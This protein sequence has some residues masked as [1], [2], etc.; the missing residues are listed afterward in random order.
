MFLRLGRG[1]RGKR[2]EKTCRK[3]R[4]GSDRKR[5]FAERRRLCRMRAKQ[6]W[7]LHQKETERRGRT[8]GSDGALTKGQFASFHHFKS[9]W[10]L[11]CHRHTVSLLVCTY[12]KG[13]FPSAAVGVSLVNM[14]TSP[15]PTCRLCLCDDL[16]R[17]WPAAFGA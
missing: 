3:E 14:F 13:G 1:T 9:A 6:P 7:Q 5:A 8:R 2:E 16:I 11:K 17:L 15:L 12:S 10:E 4:K